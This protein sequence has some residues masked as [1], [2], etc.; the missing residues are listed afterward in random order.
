MRPEF[1]GRVLDQL[2]ESD[3]KTPWMR[4][5]DNEPLQQNSSDLLLDCFSVA[6]RKQVEK[7]ATEVMSVRIWIPQ[8]VGDGIQKQ[9]AP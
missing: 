8:L 6:F 5:I 2:D 4:S 3:Q 1:E 9:V 7:S